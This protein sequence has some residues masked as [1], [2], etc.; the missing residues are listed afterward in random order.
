MRKPA[1]RASLTRRLVGLAAAVALPAACILS[2]IAEEPASAAEMALEAIAPLPADLQEE[3]TAEANIEPDTGSALQ[4]LELGT[5]NASYYGARFAGRPTANGESFDPSGFTAAHRTLPF[6]SR[7]KVTNRRNGK[8]VIVRINDRGPFHGN[9]V[10]DL[11]RGAAE[12]IGLVA[13][14]HGLVELVLLS[15]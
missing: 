12:E 11:S 2:V 14:G 4:M 5:G 9:R 8:S 1:I 3:G 6:G 15:S 10:I 7:V 13:Q